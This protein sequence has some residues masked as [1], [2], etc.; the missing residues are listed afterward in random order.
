MRIL[1]SFLIIGAAWAQQPPPE[2]AKPKRLPEPKNLKVLKVSPAELLPLMR[3]FNTALGVQCVFCHVKGDFAS[4]ENEH[5]DI[6]RMMISMAQDVNAK[7]SGGEK[8]RVTC[9]TCHRGEAHPQT[10][11]PATTDAAQPSTPPPAPAK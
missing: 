4:D 1:L 9:F 8:V 11:P 10:N 2:P 3:S 7:F 6:A 5:K